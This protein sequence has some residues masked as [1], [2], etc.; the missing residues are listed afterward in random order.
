MQAQRSARQHWV[1]RLAERHTPPP[2]LASCA[3]VIVHPK[4]AGIWSFVVALGF[5]LVMQT[6]EY[7]RRFLA[8]SALVCRREY[9]R[10]RASIGVRKKILARLKR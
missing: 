2:T 6:Q 1:Q 4:I 10:A 3:P 9:Y 8:H 7:S 5:I